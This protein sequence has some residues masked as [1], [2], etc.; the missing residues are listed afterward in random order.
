MAL[1]MPCATQPK[2]I[3][4]DMYTLL[5]EDQQNHVL[6][7]TVGRPAGDPASNWIRRNVVPEQLERSKCC[8]G[9]AGWG[10]IQNALEPASA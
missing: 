4:T 7:Q 6:N 3:Y 8:P 5:V 2:I 10:D 1:P 9:V